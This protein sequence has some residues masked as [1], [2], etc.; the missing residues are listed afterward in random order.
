MSRRALFVSLI[1]L[2]S[3]G[4]L[5]VW[6]SAGWAAEGSKQLS[7]IAVGLTLCALASRSRPLA[8]RWAALPAFLMAALALLLVLLPGVG[9]TVN[10]SQRWLSL[11]PLGSWQPS[12]F[13]KMALILILA[14]VYQGKP[15]Q[16][17]G[18]TQLGL[19]GIC[20]G[21]LFALVAKQPD[22][23]TALVLGAIYMGMSWVAGAPALGLFVL[24]CGQ[25]QRGNG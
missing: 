2:L 20:A 19:G 21:L 14:R 18:W 6:S 9:Q 15:G 10:G 25:A 17:P 7:H 24:H 12:E 13:A 4:W 3:L 5:A 11:G 23:G 16:S 8:W 22:L 1:G